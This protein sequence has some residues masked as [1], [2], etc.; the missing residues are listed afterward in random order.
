M[1]I[2]L[3]QETKPINPE[4][5]MYTQ[6]LANLQGNILKSHG[7]DFAAHIFL[8]FTG[9]PKA[10]RKWVADYTNRFVTSAFR[11]AQETKEYKLN[12]ISGRAFGGIYLSAEGY[13]KLGF[14]LDGFSE[15]QQGGSPNT[16]F[17][18]G[19]EKGRAELNDPPAA[20]WEEG[21]RGRKIH[22]M[23]LLAD[24]DPARLEDVRKRVEK[25]LKGVADVWAR[26]DGVALR[27]ENNKPVEQFGYRDGISQ[28]LYF[29]ADVQEEEEKFGTDQWDPSAPLDIVLTPDPLADK[30]DSFGSYFVFRK[31]EENVRG[32]KEAEDRLSDALGRPAGSELA[33]AQV[34]GRFENGV[35]VLLSD[36][37]NAP[38]ALLDFNNFNYGSDPSALKCP[39]QGHIRKT[40][41][42]GDTGFDGGKVNEGERRRRITRRGITYG[43]RQP[44]LEDRPTKNVGLLFQCFQSSIPDQFGFMQV[45]WAN[46]RDFARSV[47]QPPAPGAP[48]TGLD[49][50]IGQ[51]ASSAQHWPTTWGGAA[52]K[53]FDFAGFVTMKGGEYFFAPSIPFLRGLD[54]Q[55]PSVASD[56][57]EF[58][59]EGVTKQ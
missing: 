22:A 52:L 34:I 14:A 40:N 15:P 46:N 43:K 12:G 49:P 7:R 57:K 33:G 39:F 32:F 8:R 5:E 6:M 13:R 35:P 20:K 59:D 56:Q 9:K 26:E 28:P 38:P 24:E 25:S 19:M 44:G 45:Q 54:G 1:P 31:L 11:Q 37:E 27:D 17:R 50:V 53:D 36:T 41:P 16:F 18:D 48:D 2:D 55:L 3:G 21:Y 23:L 47:V 58:A 10:V 29:Q 51:G 42:R 4:D 30:P